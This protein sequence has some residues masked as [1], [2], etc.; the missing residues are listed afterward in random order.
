MATHSSTFTWKIP[1]TKEPGR[2]QSMGSKSRTQLSN[3]TF[4][5]PPKNDYFLT[6]T[7]QTFQVTRNLIIKNTQID[8]MSKR[9]SNIKK[10]KTI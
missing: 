5:F 2:L 9:K 4:T 3:F 8:D 6:N 10:K 7:D 1:W